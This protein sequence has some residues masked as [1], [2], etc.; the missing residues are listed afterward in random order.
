MLRT[1]GHSLG[2]QEAWHLLSKCDFMSNF[3]G[4]PQFFTY[5]D[6]APLDSPLPSG[7]G[8][9]WIM[10]SKGGLTA[11]PTICVEN[12]PLRLS[13]DRSSA[14]PYPQFERRD[15]N[16]LVCFYQWTI[17]QCENGRLSLVNLYHQI[18]QVVG[19]SIDKYILTNPIYN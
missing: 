1:D 6:R 8:V 7:R 10:K 4:P 19:F 14:L 18:A 17:F 3:L 15:F 11:R 9:L 13:S 12:R 2:T 5:P 16:M